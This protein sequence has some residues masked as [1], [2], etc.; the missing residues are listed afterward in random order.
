MALV[1]GAVRRT[2]RMRTARANIFDVYDVAH[3][4]K[5][6]EISEYDLIADVGVLR[7]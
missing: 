6:A 3:S 2:A 4:V 5:G 1:H 7:V